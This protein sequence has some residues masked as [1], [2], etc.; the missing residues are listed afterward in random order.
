MH[1]PHIFSRDRLNGYTKPGLSGGGRRGLGR[2]RGRFCIG[3]GGGNRGPV[4]RDGSASPC[5]HP[6]LRKNVLRRKAEYHRYQKQ[7]E[8]HF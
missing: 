3:S 6:V 1:D 2:R 5:A 8:N 4:H 7:A